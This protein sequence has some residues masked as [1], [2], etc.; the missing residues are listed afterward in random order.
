MTSVSFL[1]LYH[2]STRPS[3]RPII[4]FFSFFVLISPSTFSQLFISNHLAHL[5]LFSPSYPG[6]YQKSKHMPRPTTLGRTPPPPLPTSTMTPSNPISTVGP[7]PFVPSSLSNSTTANAKSS[8]SKTP[9]TVSPTTTKPGP[10]SSS[11][12][13]AAAPLTPKVSHTTASGGTCPGDGRCDGT[14]GTSAC[15]GCPTFNN[16]LAI[17]AR[18]ELENAAAANAAVAA[19][20]ADSPMADG[21]AQPAVIDPDLT[22]AGMES[23]ASVGGGGGAATGNNK[24]MRVAVGALCCANCGTSTTPLWRRDDVGNNICN[25]CGGLTSFSREILFFSFW[26]W[27][28]S[29]EFGRP[30]PFFLF[31]FFFMG[32]G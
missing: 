18:M 13:A 4:I 22:T 16:A 3:N 10:S 29:R 20:A 23:D 25:A 17:T 30:Q 12:N 19:S 31:S 9:A 11:T 27:R 8:S 14:G 32:S 15:S 6:L 5:L 28:V 7:S 1:R 21:A 24:K 26:G 2:P